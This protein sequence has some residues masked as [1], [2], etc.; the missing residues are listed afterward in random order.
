MYAGGINP[1]IGGTAG[2]VGGVLA[3][4]GSP[5]LGLMLAIGAML[6][7]AGLT[8]VRKNVVARNLAALGGDVPRPFGGG[9]V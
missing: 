6:I 8:F 2:G 1:H 7:F 4:T 3:A 5:A 9:A